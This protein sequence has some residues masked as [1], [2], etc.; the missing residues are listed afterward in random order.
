MKEFERGL[1]N[2][3][4]VNMAVTC[5][6]SGQ[7]SLI[8]LVVQLNYNKIIVVFFHCSSVAVLLFTSLGLDCQV[9]RPTKGT[10]ARVLRV[11]VAV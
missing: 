8:D 7:N 5:L 6:D 10:I 11:A 3:S 2:P 9:P 4:G 1:T